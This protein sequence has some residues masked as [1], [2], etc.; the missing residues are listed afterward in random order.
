MNVIKLMIVLVLFFTLCFCGDNPIV[1][2]DP[3]VI[4]AFT[5]QPKLIK[6]CPVQP[7]SDGLYSVLN[8]VA[9][10]PEGATVYYSFDV[11]PVGAGVNQPNPMNGMGIFEAAQTGQYAVICNACDNLQKGNCSTSGLYIKVC[12]T[13]GTS[14]ETAIGSQAIANEIMKKYGRK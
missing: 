8:C 10:D 7:C 1:P 11:E 9:M 14:T 3:P 5:A 6:T 4:T 13:C 12:D 2:N